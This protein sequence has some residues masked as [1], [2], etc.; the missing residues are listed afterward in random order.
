MAVNGVIEYNWENPKHEKQYVLQ[1]LYQE[2]L[3]LE[4]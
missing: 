1:C 3:S 4:I 2:V